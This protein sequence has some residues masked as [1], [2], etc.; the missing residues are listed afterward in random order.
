MS[1][2]SAVTGGAATSG[3]GTAL[4]SGEAM[5]RFDENGVYIPRA[6]TEDDLRGSSLE[7]AMVGT[8]VEF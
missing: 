5:G 2:V 6:I 7:D 1:D 3:G 4:L 8:I